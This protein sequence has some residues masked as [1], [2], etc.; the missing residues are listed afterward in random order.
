[1]LFTRVVF[2]FPFSFYP[3]SSS[4]LKFLENTIGWGFHL[5][6]APFLA[7]MVIFLFI[8][9]LNLFGLYDIRTPGGTLIGNIDVDQSYKG[10]FI[11]G[12]L[13]TV[14]ST[15][16]SAPFLGVA[17]TFAFTSPFHYTLL[18]F[19]SVGLGLSL[20]F[21]LIGFFPSL[22][23]VLP[24]PGAWMDHFKKILGL[25]LLLTGFWLF[26]VFQS[27][28]THSLSS[29]LLILTLVLIFFFFF[30][31]KKVNLKK[32]QKSLLLALPLCSFLYLVIFQLKEIP[33]HPSTK[34]SA[35][36]E[37]LGHLWEKWSP[38]KMVEYQKLGQLVFVD[39][40]AK[41]CFTCIV[42]EKLVL[43]TNEFK[44]LIKE[45]KVK[46]LYADWTKRDPII[47]GWLKK[48]GIFG[49]PAYFI[50]THKGDLINLGET[51]SI[52]EIREN[53]SK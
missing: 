14:L 37:R 47:G 43:N 10:D 16:C 24:K 35:T 27:I 53:L 5:Q 18:I 23:K 29:V 36:A 9:S 13:A 41:W 6:S 22:L 21:L 17:L 1:M 50:Q 39:F 52:Q 44:K 15:P 34:V 4:F 25:S 45:K 8:L 48:Q 38:E 19:L 42:N 11:S 33:T 26:D 20:P 32:L 7:I 46:A 2:F 40:T 49:L 28:I 51:I 31:L 3:S 12:L 30:V